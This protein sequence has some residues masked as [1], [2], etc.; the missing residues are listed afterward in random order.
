MAFK[1][2]LPILCLIVLASACYKVQP[3]TLEVTIKDGAGNVVPNA[4]VYVGGESTVSPSPDLE[5]VYESE[6]NSNGVVLF[7]LSKGS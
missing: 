2:I 6:T 5:A 7:D 4:L 1:K 3:T